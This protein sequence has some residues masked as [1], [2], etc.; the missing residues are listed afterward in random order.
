VQPSDARGRVKSGTE[1]LEA[2]AELVPGGAEYDAMVAKVKAKYGV[3]VPV[4]KVFN[5]LGHLF[6]GRYPYADRGVLVTLSGPSAP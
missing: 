6:K 5:T 3:M 4:S 1:P 2:T